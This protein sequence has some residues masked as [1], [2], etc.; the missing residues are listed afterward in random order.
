MSPSSGYFD[1]LHTWSSLLSFEEFRC[2][3][4]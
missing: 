1:T 2:K 3:S 4:L